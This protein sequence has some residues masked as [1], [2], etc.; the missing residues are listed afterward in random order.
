MYR[1]RSIC[2]FLNTMLQKKEIIVEILNFISYKEKF[3]KISGF[4]LTYDI[5][6]IGI[7]SFSAIRTANYSGRTCDVDSAKTSTNS[8][9]EI[10]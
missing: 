2:C 1:P 7:S 5:L 6:Y 3:P 8:V 4:L 10:S 9:R